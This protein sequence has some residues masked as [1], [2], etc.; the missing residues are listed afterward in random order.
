M[1]L[2]AGTIVGNV[3][4]LGPWFIPRP[5]S[6]GALIIMLSETDI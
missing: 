3:D 4:L 6:N 2:D 1:E 5:I